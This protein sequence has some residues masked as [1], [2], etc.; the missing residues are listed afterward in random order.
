[1]ARKSRIIRAVKPRGTTC[2]DN[3]RACFDG[4]E[5]IV[6]DS[7]TEC[8]V[9]P[10]I[11]NGKIKN[12]D[13]VQHRHV[14]Q[15]LDGIGQNR[16]DVFAVDFDVAIAARDIFAVLV[17]QDDKAQFFQVRG[18][19]VEPFGN[20]VQEVF[21]DNAIGVFL[22]VFYVVLGRAAFGNVGVQ[23]V[24]AGGQATAALDIRLFDNQDFEARTFV[25]RSILCSSNRG[26][27]T[28]RAAADNQQVC[29]DPFYFH[30]TSVQSAGAAKYRT[31]LLPCP[32]LN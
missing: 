32:I 23:C 4:V 15:F 16:L 9:N 19:F 3:D 22:R 5:C 1:M 8:A 20:A 10:I 26:V 14:I 2:R 29:L 18:D 24:Y 25:I 6:F 31:R 21:A 28:G 13:V 30:S 27:T 11:V 17:F 12:V 7:E